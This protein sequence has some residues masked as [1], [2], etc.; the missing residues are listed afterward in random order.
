MVQCVCV[1][2]WVCVCVCVLDRSLCDDTS[3]VCVCVV[4][5]VGGCSCGH[6]LYHNTSMWGLYAALCL[7]RFHMPTVGAMA[8]EEQEQGQ[9]QEQREEGEEE[10]VEEQEEE[11]EE[12]N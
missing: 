11:Q 7:K 4:G 9:G 2:V 8:G 5:R 10:K 6:S 12:K 1:C 3:S